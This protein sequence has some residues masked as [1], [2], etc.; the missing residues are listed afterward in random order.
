MRLATS[1]ETAV[2]EDLIERIGISETLNLIAAVCALKSFV[3]D[4]KDV[5]E[6]WSEL[7]VKISDIADEF[8]DTKIEG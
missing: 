5:R 4:D 1:A 7:G 8:L 6:Q 3:E 2:V